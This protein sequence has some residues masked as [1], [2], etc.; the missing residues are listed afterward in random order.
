MI[1]GAFKYFYIKNVFCFR[2]S[3]KILL[4]E[5]KIGSS[6]TAIFTF[7]FFNLCLN[8]CLVRSIILKQC[9]FQQNVVNSSEAER[10][11]LQFLFN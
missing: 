7:Y 4:F 3:P 9:V 6:L 8:A 5:K 11:D 1:F 10:V 2:N